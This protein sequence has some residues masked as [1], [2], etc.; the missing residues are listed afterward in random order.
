MFLHFFLRD[1]NADSLRGLICPL[2][3]LSNTIRATQSDYINKSVLHRKTRMHSS[4]M[5][6]A[7]SLPYGGLSGRPPR[8][9]P[10][11]TETPLERDPQTETPMDRDPPGKRPPDRDP[12][13][14]ETPPWTE[15]PEKRPPGK[16]PPRQRPL[17]DRD[18]SGQRTPWTE[19]PLDRDPHGH[20]TCDAY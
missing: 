10:P 14:T 13:Q 4:R 16:R 11:W 2:F 6:T 3:S 18:P 15:T 1:C 20:V 8:Q 5:R 19:T 12:S 17:L 7:R 9:R